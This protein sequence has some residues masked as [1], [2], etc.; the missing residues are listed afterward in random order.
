MLQ[1][2]IKKKPEGVLKEHLDKIKKRKLLKYLCMALPY[3][4]KMYTPLGVGHLCDINLNAISIELGI[5]IDAI[6][7]DYFDIIDCKPYLRPMSTMTEEEKIEY[8]TFL[9]DIE[10]YCYSIDCVPQIDWLLEHH[11]DFMGLIPMSM[12]IDYSN[13]EIYDYDD[14]D[15]KF[16]YNDFVNG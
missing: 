3:G 10:G 6:K 4:V 1:E 14:T 7:R 15:D 9:E 8:K 12:A 2:V 5:N 13:L 11:F 16:S